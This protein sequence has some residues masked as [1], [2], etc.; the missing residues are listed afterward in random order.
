V[1]CIGYHSV[2]VSSKWQATPGKRLLEV[3]V[4]HAGDYLRLTLPRAAARYCVLHFPSIM[5]AA[6]F[7]LQ[8]NP[9]TW[10]TPDMTPEERG[11]FTQMITQRHQQPPLTEEQKQFLSPAGQATFEAIKTKLDKN[12]PL[13]ANE[14]DFLNRLMLPVLVVLHEGKDDCADFIAMQDKAGKGI[15]LTQ[16]QQQRVNY[17]AGALIVSGM[18]KDNEK[19]FAMGRNPLTPEQQAVIGKM[20]EGAKHI[21]SSP[22][23]LFFALMYLYLFLQAAMIAW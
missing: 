5:I 23:F 12:I 13:A 21:F 22:F 20:G 2:F 18:V 15:A 8:P 11:V 14:Q 9:L 1:L 16:P 10:L 19:T 17:L 3:Y 7:I 6:F 4:V